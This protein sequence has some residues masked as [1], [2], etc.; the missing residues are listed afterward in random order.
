MLQEWCESGTNL[1]IEQGDSEQLISYWD[2]R[3]EL[4]AR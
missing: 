4:G 3:I 1:L 2:Y